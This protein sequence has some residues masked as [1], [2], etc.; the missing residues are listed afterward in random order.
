[1]I[2]NTVL[3]MMLSLISLIAMAQSSGKYEGYYIDTKGNKVVGT[4]PT[5]GN[6]I[7]TPSE[8][9]F[10]PGGDQN[11][12]INLKPGDLKEFHVEGWDSYISRTF[13]RQVNLVTIE[14]KPVNFTGYSDYERLKED[15]F[16]TVTGFLR[17]VVDGSGYTLYEYKDELR[18]NFFIQ[19]GNGE[20]VPLRFKV[21]AHQRESVEKNLI[22]PQIDYLVQLNQIFAHKLAKNQSAQRRL[23]FI[24]YDN[25]LIEFVEELLQVEKEKPVVSAKQVEMSSYPAH[26]AVGGGVS[27]NMAKVTPYQEDEAITRAKFKTQASPVIALSFYFYSKRNFGKNFFSPQ[28]LFFKYKNYGHADRKKHAYGYHQADSGY[29]ESSVIFFNFHA[30]RHWVKKENFSWYTSIAPS[31]Q[32]LNGNRIHSW[33][34]TSTTGRSMTFSVM[35]QTGIVIYKNWNL[36]VAANR[37]FSTQFKMKYH[38]RH[39]DVQ[40]GVQYMIAIPGT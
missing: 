34:T 30:G 1:M 26:F 31:V 3:S 9:K 15:S 27:L 21:F 5:Y 33:G 35:L 22:V 36:Y 20:I 32:V 18:R 10:A 8:I 28:V 25:Q 39:D 17:K 7:N 40:F 16:V 12:V 37:I 38:V 23:M 29:V 11:S 19:Q 13:Q 6:W 14:N 24:D 2:R 4:F